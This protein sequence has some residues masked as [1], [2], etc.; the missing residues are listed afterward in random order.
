VSQNK[1]FSAAAFLLDEGFNMSNNF[2]LGDQAHEHVKL[3][4]P[5]SDSNLGV[6]IGGFVAMALLCLFIA[7]KCDDV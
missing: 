1:D 7:V 6:L 4:I 5:K 3:H 2:R